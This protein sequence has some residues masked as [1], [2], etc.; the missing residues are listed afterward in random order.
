MK[1]LKDRL[2]G[3]L[4]KVMLPLDGR[5]PRVLIELDERECASIGFALIQWSMLEA[6]IKLATESLCAFKQIDVPKDADQDS[7][8][9][10]LA[11]FRA[12]L[13]T[14]KGATVHEL[15]WPLLDKIARENGVRQGIT[16]GLWAYDLS[17]P[18]AIGVQMTRGKDAGI[19]HSLTT[20]ELIEFAERVGE[21]LFVLMYPGGSDQWMEE[22]AEAL[23]ESGGYISREFLK[24]ITQP[25]RPRRPGRKNK[26]TG[27]GD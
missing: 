19:A 15:W 17:D 8:R 22:R 13:A 4:T 27:T 3:N 1:R 2:T 20:D 25:K 11:A 16:H 10:R 26:D 24:M 7:F 12:V 21:I 9:R 18:H 6:Q 23:E 5:K 14:F